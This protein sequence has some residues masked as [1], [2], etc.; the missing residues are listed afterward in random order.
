MG[1]EK[2]TPDS[3]LSGQKGINL[4]EEVVLDMGFLWH[5]AGPF[6][7]GIDGRIELRDVRTR[8][9]LNRYLGVQ[10][11]GWQKYTA[12]DDNGFGFL[13]DFADVDYWMQSDESVLL[14]CSHPRTRQAWFKV[15]TDWFADA[16]RRAS[17]RIV[18]DKQADRFD[19][20]RAVDLLRLGMRSEPALHRRPPPPPEQLVTNLLPILEHGARVWSAPTEF[21]DHRQVHTRYEEV[22]GGRAS[23]YLL[24]EGRLYSLRDPRSCPLR[25]L[26][27]IAQLA[28]VPAD[29]WADSN[30]PRVR[31]Y[32]VELLRR[33][34]LHQVKHQL[35]WHFTRGL[36]YVPAPDPLA[37]VS[38]EG[39]KGPRLVV[40]VEHYLDK[41][42][43]ERRLKYVRHHAFRPGFVRVD[44]HWRL[45]VE[46]EYLFTY[47]GERENFR[48]DEY[49]AGIKR[50]DRNLAV[51][52]QLRMWEY[53]L[54]RP[55]S[56]LMPEPPLLT[57]GPLETVEA[58]V[59]IDDDLWRGKDAGGREVAGG[60]DELAA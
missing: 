2:I 4:V 27:D 39:P 35:R 56:L 46:P 37:E 6:D 25:H 60:Q 26:C 8:K 52:G 9:P 31:R 49:L 7:A 42:R 12:E 50:L 38:I 17:R 57:F 29:D 19:S 47:D 59:G 23:D 28:S 44:G 20:S 22:G 14:V 1:T 21:Y 45:E 5:P 48:A 32:W 18:F 34:L 54:T 40:K 43:G 33:T 58:P 13:C 16:E 41:R 51:V 30:E 11:K 55:P 10:S 3:E 24:R 15:V 53:F 36:F